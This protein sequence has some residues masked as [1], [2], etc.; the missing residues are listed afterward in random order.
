MATYYLRDTSVG[1]CADGSKG[2]DLSTDQ[3]TPAG[4]VQATAGAASYSVILTF[5][6]V[7]GAAGPTGTI[8]VSVDIN[9]LSNI[10]G[11]RWNLQRV[12]S[13]CEVQESSG[14]SAEYT[15]TGVKTD[16]IS[17]SPTW[18]TGDQLRLSVEGKKSGA[19]G[20]VTLN[21]QDADSW[22]QEP[23]ASDDLEA[24]GL[25][26]TPT[27][28]GPTL[29]HQYNLTAT[30]VAT[31]PALGGPT[32][33]QEHAL[34]ATG[35][36][37]T[38]ALGAPTLTEIKNLTANGLATTPTV[39]IPTLAVIENLTSQDLAG[40]TPTLAAP[41]LGQKHVLSASGLVGGT[42]TLGAPSIGQEHVLGASGLT[43]GTPIL[44]SPTVGQEHALAT[45][46]LEGGTATLGSPIIGQV[47]VLA[48]TGLG[49]TP[50]LGAPTLSAEG[51]D[52][53]DASDLAVTPV[54]GAPAISQEHALSATGLAPIPVVGTPTLVVVI[55]LVASNL[56]GGT[57][58]FGAPAIGQV[59]ALSTTGLES[60][61][62]TGTPTLGVSGEDNLTA[63]DL[64]GA[65][66]D[67]GSPVIGQTHVLYA[68][69]LITTPV[70]D[71]PALGVIGEDNLAA[72]DLVGGTPALG[73][74]TLGQ[75]HAL[76]SSGLLITVDLGTPTLAGH[77]DLTASS[78]VGGTPVLGVPT[79]TSGEL[80]IRMSD[81]HGITE[82][83]KFALRDLLTEKMITELPLWDAMRDCQVVI[84]KIQ[85]D[86]LFVNVEIYEGFTPDPDSWPHRAKK[87]PGPRNLRNGQILDPSE[88]SQRV[89]N[90]VGKLTMSGWSL[91]T[92]A[93]TVE[94]EIAGNSAVIDVDRDDVTQACGIAEARVRRSLLNAG[95]KMGLA[96]PPEDDFGEKVLQGPFFGD[97]WMERVES[98]SLR[99][100]RY[101]QFWYE[102]GY[103][104]PNM[105]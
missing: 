40:G 79:L 45:G 3:G 49:P 28:G 48:A 93:L 38:P 22:V 73:Q 99:T 2:F 5:D 47:H 59:H 26:T 52:N 15:T 92:R 43:G 83:I 51:Q 101:I 100:K 31:T 61:P 20:S 1:G 98:E 54:L 19:A 27:V 21:V 4:T 96:L 70:L 17:F 77:V 67:L 42:P 63:D 57:P 89:R 97:H 88:D 80:V 75:I 55:N 105:A 34:S 30:G 90:A 9:A 65:A 72:N 68:S 103:A 78:L 94:L 29:G 60:T 85:D 53:L 36:G 25:E 37:S 81:L 23:A 10:A 41:T 58:A 14:Y 16:D 13:I 95:P 35:I 6:V 69:N 66:P 24:S 87:L 11:V 104:G 50:V 18:A 91:N 102:T 12:N 44:G 74:P 76:T 82:L 64:S 39:G 84:G 33:G 71:A 32:V 8:S 62:A 56:T 7:V 46:G 86:P